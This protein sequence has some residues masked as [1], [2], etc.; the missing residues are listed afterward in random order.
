MNQEQSQYHT[1]TLLGWNNITKLALVYFF[2]TLYFYLPVGTLYLRSRGLSYVEI[3]SLWGIIVA[4]MFLTEVPTGI[5][6]D[7]WGHKRAVIIAL[8][9][10]LLGE[11]IYI[12]ADSFWSFAASSIVAGLGFAFSSGCIEALVYDELRALQREEEMSKAMGLIQAAQH[13]ANL[14]AFATGGLLIRDLTQ[15]RFVMG[16]V[17]TACAVAV[18]WLFTF[19]LRESP[20]RRTST[21]KAGSRKLLTDGLQLLRRNPQFRHL[22]LLTLATIPFVNYLGMY[23]SRLADVG[24]SS[25]LLGLARALA[26]G[27][28][29][30]G[31][32]YAY[33]L[34]RWLGDSQSL[35]LVTALPG[36]LFLGAALAAHP[37]WSIIAFCTLSASMSLKDPILSGHLNRHIDRQNRATVLSLISMASGLYVSLMGVLIGRIGDTSL[38]AAFV[39][40]GTTVLMGAVAFRIR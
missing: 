34:E 32:R 25:T 8:A 35:L 2:S 13:T 24:V 19:T 10:Q 37:F 26:A 21:D 17:V 39:F 12:F 36:V 38:T 16:I 6:A 3:N 14:L 22:V 28:S 23:Q 20:T 18:G 27:L 9:L 33:R 29:I 40:M 31:A 7:R 4:T 11:V 1:R 15:T 30:L 5:L